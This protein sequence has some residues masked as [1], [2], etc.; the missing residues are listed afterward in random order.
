MCEIKVATK[1]CKIC[2][3]S[4]CDSC[5]ESHKTLFGNP[6]IFEDIENEPTGSGET[7]K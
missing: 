1:Y 7:S 4:Y 6:V 5:S 3:T 2:R